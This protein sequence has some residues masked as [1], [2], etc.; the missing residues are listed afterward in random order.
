MPLITVEQ[1]EILE[2]QGAQTAPLLRIF[3]TKTFVESSGDT[4]M[5]S[6]IEEGDFYKELECTAVTGTVT[7]P[8]FTIHS[9]ADALSDPQNTAYTFA[10]FT[11]T[12]TL[13]QLVLK[14]IRVPAT[15]DPTTLGDL[16]IYSED[17][18]VPVPDGA[19]TTAQVDALIAALLGKQTIWVPA[20]AMTSR[21]TS[22]A[23]ATSREINSITVPVLA[24]DAAADEGANFS[25]S[26][27]KSWNAGTITF[28]PK[29]TCNGGSAAE[30]VQFELRGGCF[31]DDAAINVTG[32]GTAVAVTDTRIATND[33]HDAA[34]S[35]AV[36]L[37]N[38]A[39]SKLAFFEI[40]RD[41]SDDT[42]SV[43]AELIGI[44]IYYTVDA[45]NDA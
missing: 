34:E 12:G 29:W 42:L 40:I 37:A 35:S 24:F 5:R 8:E 6:S 2:Y 31:A 18:I 19:Y 26:M 23:Q 28:K 13:I 39:K 38:A 22:G 11:A 21:T 9:T 16:A 3:A 44:D 15:P 17:N 32:F 33:V 20:A 7:Y 36:T 14:N 10:L 1:G 45:H 30:T 41:V 25:V 27:P 43:D 4:I